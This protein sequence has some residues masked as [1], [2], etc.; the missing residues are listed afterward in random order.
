MGEKNVESDFIFFIDTH[1]LYDTHDTK[2]ANNIMDIY[3]ISQDVGYRLFTNIE[4][5]LHNLS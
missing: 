2:M 4:Y 1:N 3:I 5:I